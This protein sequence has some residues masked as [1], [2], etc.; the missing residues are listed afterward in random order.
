MELSEWKVIVVEDNYD[1]LEMVSKIL[2]HYHIKVETAH[3]GDE[4]LRL[5]E[6][7]SPT[8][9]ITD[10]AMP[11]KDGWET[12]AA[13]RRNPRT[14]HIPVVA[15]TAFHSDEIANDLTRIG[16]N[17]YIPKPINPNT[18]IQKLSAMLPK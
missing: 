10:L 11:G 14:R 7:F 18:F 1:D 8:L 2:R 3:N 6:H 15:I 13:V 9:I 5:L 17:G 16:F 4:C 12:L